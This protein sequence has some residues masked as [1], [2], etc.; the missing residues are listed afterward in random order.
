MPYVKE[1]EISRISRT[2]PQGIRQEG[3][4]SRVFMPCYGNIS[5]WRYQL[6]EVIRLGGTNFS[7]GDGFYPLIIKVASITSARMQVY[8]IEN[9]DCFQR[10][11]QTLDEHGNLFDDNHRRMIFFT[12]GT[13]TSIKKLLWQPRV[14]HC[15]GWFTMLMPMY[16]KKALAKDPFFAKARVVVSVY[17]E[18]FKGELN[19]ALAQNVVVPGIRAQDTALLQRPN[20]VNLM[21]HA[22]SYADGVIIG[23]EKINPELMEYIETIKAPVL[24]Y[25]TPEQQT[26]AYAAFYVRI[27]KRG[28]VC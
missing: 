17:D 22:I 10:R 28:K 5:M 7:I 13:I 2:L 1:T 26:K 6:H 19:P 20:Y 27:K 16:I 23:S 21:K 4:D 15:H 9:E 24:P 3:F 18:T 25:Q 8:F 11:Y 14:V 12:R